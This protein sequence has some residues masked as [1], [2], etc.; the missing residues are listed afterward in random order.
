MAHTDW[1][2][3]AQSLVDGFSSKANPDDR[4]QL[5]EQLCDRLGGNLYPAFLHILFNIEQYADAPAKTLVTS[6]LVY[7]LNTGRLPSGKLAAWGSSQLPSNSAFGQTRS[8]GPIEYIC[9]WYAQPSDQSSIP[10]SSFNTML[11][12]LINLV[13]YDH[14]AKSLY[15]SKLLADAEDPLGGGMSSQTR[16]AIGELATS[17]QAGN[18]AQKIARQFTD[19]LQDNS[20]LAQMSV[21]RLPNL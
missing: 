21:D 20:L 4:I 19:S 18:D 14:T 15:C 11:T 8:L 12:S 13:D 2:A 7:G 3:A 10:L 9:A 5:T 6:T 16:V 1:H 17:W